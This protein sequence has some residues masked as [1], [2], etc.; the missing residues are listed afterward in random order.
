MYYNRYSFRLYFCYKCL[1]YGLYR[2]GRLC[3]GLSLRIILSSLCSAMK[4]L[5][6]FL[7]RITRYSHLW[8]FLTNCR[9]ILC[10]SCVRNGHIISIELLAGTF[11]PDHSLH[12]RPIFAKVSFS[13]RAL[14]PRHPHHCHHHILA[15]IFARLAF[16]L[17]PILNLSHHRLQ[18]H[19]LSFS[20]VLSSWG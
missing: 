4:F 20:L 6:S 17:L 5:C 2:C 10:L 3:S 8:P 15:P 18:S 19:L 11:K 14:R 7:Y 12:L 9:S 16:P 1:S 13:P